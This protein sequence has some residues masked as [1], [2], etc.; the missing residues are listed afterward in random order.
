MK[1]IVEGLNRFVI[2][3]DN[4]KDVGE[5]LLVDGSYILYAFGKRHGEVKS[6]EQ[7]VDVVEQLEKELLEELRYCE[8][9]LDELFETYVEIS[10]PRIQNLLNKEA[11]RIKSK[12]G[13]ILDKLVGDFE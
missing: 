6:L 1:I 7:A 12:H 13:E 3:N 8:S 4:M 10:L 2:L 5:V 9:Y 11:E